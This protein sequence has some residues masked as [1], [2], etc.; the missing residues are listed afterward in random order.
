MKEQQRK[1]AVNS[2]SWVGNQ[3][4]AKATHHRYTSILELTEEKLIDSVMDKNV[5]QKVYSTTCIPSEQ[6]F[7]S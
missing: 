6:K 2:M 3:L 7:S 1:P 4:L 5:Y